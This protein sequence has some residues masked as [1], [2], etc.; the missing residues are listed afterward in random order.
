MKWLGCL[1]HDRSLFLYYFFI[2][3]QTLPGLGTVQWSGDQVSSAVPVEDQRLAT[4]KHSAPK[5]DLSSAE[6]GEA[7]VGREAR[8]GETLR[9]E[10]WESLGCKLTSW[11]T[12][13]WITSG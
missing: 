11:T 2:P 9:E 12:E 4:G 13:A 5:A 1:Q 7:V 10:G 8:A 3:A 6:R